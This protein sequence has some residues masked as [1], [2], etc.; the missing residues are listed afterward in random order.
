LEP[1][2]YLQTLKYRG[3]IIV[4]GG[5][6]GRDAI[7]F[8]RS[9]TFS[10][11]VTVDGI[12]PAA[13]NF[14]PG[15]LENDRAAPIELLAT[16]VSNRAELFLNIDTG[17]HDRKWFVTEVPIGPE[18]IRVSAI[19]LD[20]VCA[21]RR[22]IDVIKISVDVHELEILE[23][24]SQ[25][26]RRQHPDLCVETNFGHTESLTGLLESYGYLQ[27]ETLSHMNLYFVHVGR[28]AV[29]ITRILSAA[30]FWIA[31]R[32]TWRWKRVICR[33]AMM[34]RRWRSAPREARQWGH[35]AQVV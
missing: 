33:I 19:T 23:S 20:E 2:Q 34:R 8:S 22:N 18:S 31:S 16:F 13:E 15:I 24:G 14:L 12:G 9:C 35:S 17:S 29:A 32:S 21:R 3:T 6:T 7:F 4:V 1:L 10:R 25:T 30:P 5:N 28:N 27:G 11:V 26:L